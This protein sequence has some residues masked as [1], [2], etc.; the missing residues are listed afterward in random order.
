MAPMTRTS[1]SKPA[2]DRRKRRRI[3]AFIGILLGGAAAFLALGHASGPYS[4]RA[5]GGGHG[6]IRWAETRT[7]Y[8]VEP[9]LA[10]EWIRDLRK[11]G[12]PWPT[13]QPLEPPGASFAADGAEHTVA[14]YVIQS[15][16]TTNELWHVEKNS[17][18]VL[19]AEGQEVFWPGGTGAVLIDPDRNLQYLYV[20]VPR[21]LSG[22]EA[23]IRFRL[24]RFDGPTTPEITLPF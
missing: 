8:A 12:L 3:F 15:S 21:Q 6:R 17:V 13:D 11:R 4:W 1:P 20:G 19:D 9:P 16:R 23:R 2:T 10:P 7:D 5:L 14:W 22:T 18:R 24:S